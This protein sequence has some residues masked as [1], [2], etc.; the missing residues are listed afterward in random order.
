ME[1]R[2]N[3]Q[4]ALGRWHA[5]GSG[6]AAPWHR[7]RIP[8]GRSRPDAGI[9][10]C[11]FAGPISRSAGDGQCTT[12]PMVGI[13]LAMPSRVSMR[14]FWP[15][16]RPDGCSPCRN[17]ALRHAG[18]RATRVVAIRTVVRAQRTQRRYR[19]DDARWIASHAALR[20][21][22]IG[23]PRILMA[24]KVRHALHDILEAIERVERSRTTRRLPNSRGVGSCAGSC[25]EQS[26]S[27]RKRAAAFRPS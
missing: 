12:S 24:R 3:H 26:R 22:E 14:T 15:M 10:T 20:H 21:R 18:P 5:V 8:P 9:T 7:R 6:R 23:R 4:L 19:R 11:R 17:G 27:F 25:N 1:R 13:D 2:W 16:A